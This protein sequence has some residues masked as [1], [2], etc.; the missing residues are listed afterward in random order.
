MILAA[1]IF[2]RVRRFLF[3]TMAASIKMDLLRSSGNLRANSAAIWPPKE[4]PIRVILFRLFLV[5]K[6][7]INF[8]YSGIPDPSAKFLVPP[9]PGKSRR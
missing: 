6:F 7:F 2:N 1:K 8:T 9:K 3:L 4:W 5:T